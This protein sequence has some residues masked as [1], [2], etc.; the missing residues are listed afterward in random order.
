MRAT[1]GRLKSDYRYSKDIVYN[2]FPWP[3]AAEKERRNIEKLARDV[4]AAREKYPDNTLAELY[5]PLTM[6]PDLLKAHQN[7]DKAVLRL[8]GLPAR[9]KEP[10]IAAKLLRLYSD[11]TK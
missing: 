2:N 7:L 1:A 10:E 6:P 8:Y 5:D 4:L 11:R 9:A 3:N